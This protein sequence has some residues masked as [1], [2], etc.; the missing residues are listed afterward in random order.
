MLL[1]EDQWKLKALENQTQLVEEDVD[2]VKQDKGMRR[3]LRE[4][5]ETPP[6]IPSTHATEFQARGRCQQ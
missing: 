2:S 1:V 5:L 3:L 4:Q 6:P